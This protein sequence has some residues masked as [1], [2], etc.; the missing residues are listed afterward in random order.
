MVFRKLHVGVACLTPASLPY[1]IDVNSK[2]TAWKLV[3]RVK[4]G[5]TWHPAKDHCLGSQEYNTN[6]PGSQLK[7]SEA[8]VTWSIKWEKEPYDQILFASGDAQHWLITT[9]DAVGGAFNSRY[10]SNAQRSIIKSSDSQTPYTAAWYNRVGVPED[11]WISV[12]DH[13]PAIADGK[14]VYGENNWGSASHNDLTQ[15]HNGAN[16]FIRRIAPVCE[17]GWTGPP[18]ACSLCVPGK[19]KIASGDAACVECQVGKSSAT[20]GASA[21]STCSEC[22]AGTYSATSGATICTDCESG[23]FSATVGASAA[24]TCSECQSGTYSA[25]LG[26]ASDET[27]TD[28]MAGTYS[29]TEGAST[30]SSCLSCGVGKFSATVGASAASRCSECQAGTYSATSGATICTNCVEGKYS[31]VHGATTPDVCQGC[32]EMPLL[33]CGKQQGCLYSSVGS[34]NIKAC[35]CRL[36]TVDLGLAARFAVLATNTV[37]DT[38]DST[39]NG[40]MGTS[41]GT[42]LPVYVSYVKGTPGLNGTRH[43]NDRTAENARRAALGAWLDIQSRSTCLTALGGVA[44]LGGLTLKPGLYTST[45]SFHSECVSSTSCMPVDR[46][47]QPKMPNLTGSDYMC[48][49]SNVCPCISFFS[50]SHIGRSHSGCG[51]G[52]HGYRLR[53][54][55]YFPH[56]HH[57]V[58]ASWQEGHPQGRRQS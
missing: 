21:A 57:A 35:R 42:T 43:P 4:A 30:A 1:L 52:Q 16:V 45:S 7:N 19:Y 29:A 50:I 37:T 31:T 32:P 3:R 27:C 48:E 26:A 10:Y 40:D 9:K 34:S 14:L 47:Y 49:I 41:T 25:T 11:P 56:T 15:N 6:I 8:D 5:T 39:I 46:P 38:M 20:V 2:Y 28:C 23:K 18:G 33:A 53:R 36:A 24:S 51:N 12:N 22:Q 54:R 17:P 44:E 13:H 58:N 55:L